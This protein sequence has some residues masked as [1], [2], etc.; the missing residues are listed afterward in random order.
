[1][2]ENIF[3]TWKEVRRVLSIMG[4]DQNSA[5][6]GVLGGITGLLGAHIKLVEKGILPNERQIQ[7]LKRKKDGIEEL[8]KFLEHNYYNPDTGEFEENDYL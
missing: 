1:M 3:E 4:Y 5:V 8:L 6:V 7:L 2:T